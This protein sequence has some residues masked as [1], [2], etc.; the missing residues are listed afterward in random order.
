MKRKTGIQIVGLDAVSP[1]AYSA[2]KSTVVFI[3]LVLSLN[4]KWHFI[5]FVLN[6]CIGNETMDL[7]I[8]NADFQL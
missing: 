6:S 2:H 7:R 4:E 1:I 5:V 8:K 3:Y